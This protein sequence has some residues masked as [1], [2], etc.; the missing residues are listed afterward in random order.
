MSLPLG[1]RLNNPG[2][3]RPGREKWAGEIGANG[4]F[5]EF[6]TMPNGIRALGKNLIAYY[7]NS[8]GEHPKYRSIDG[9]QIDTVKEAIYRWAPPADHNDTNAYVT[10]VCTELDCATDDVFDFRDRNFLFWMIAAIGHQEQG[11]AFTRTVSDADILAGVD[12]ALA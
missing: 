9:T 10:M 7:D 1:L 11:G 3:I 2:N 8:G 4:G 6:D 12:A 5:V